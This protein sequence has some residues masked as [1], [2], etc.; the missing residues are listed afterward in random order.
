MS[1][2]KIPSLSSTPSAPNSYPRLKRARLSLGNSMLHDVT[3]NV[4]NRLVSRRSLAG[5][6]STATTTSSSSQS[7]RLMNKY[8][9]GDANVIEEVKKRERKILK[10]I[11]RFINAIA[12]IEKE[13]VQIKERQLPDIQYQISKKKTMCNELEKEILQLTSQLD[14]KEGECE[15]QRKNEELSISNLQF[16]YSVEVQE[17]ENELEEKLN[18]EK[19]NWERQVLELE[20]M[21]PSEKIAQEIKDLKDELVQVNAE[22]KKVQLDNETQRKKYESKLAE[23][24]VTFKKQKEEPMISLLKEQ[25]ELEAK[26][27]NL[28]KENENLEDEINN[29]VQMCIDIEKEIESL[30]QN[31]ASLENK[32]SPL[33]N[34]YEKVSKEFETAEKNLKSVQAKALEKEILYNEE[35]DKMEQEQIRRRKLENSIDELKGSIRC[36]AYLSESTLTESYKIDY[37]KKTIESVDLDSKNNAVAKSYSFT[38]LIPSTLLSEDDLLFQEYQCYHDMCLENKSNFNLISVGTFPWANLVTALTKF[39]FPKYLHD[40]NIS[41]QHVFLSED[42]PSQDLLLSSS[43]NSDNEIKLKIEEDSIELDSR[44]INITSGVEDLPS[45]FFEKRVQLPSG[46][47]I[48]KL[49]FTPKNTD[50]DENIVNYYFVEIYDGNTISTLNKAVT[51][52]ESEKTPITLI[53]KKLLSDTKSCFVFNLNDTTN[54][55]KLLDVSQKIMKL[56]NPKKKRKAQQ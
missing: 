56:K 22:W 23:E 13:T 52:G 40:Y 9:F 42:V 10:D 49:T 25:K 53:L 48:L 24:F 46:I 26:K 30:N 55:N 5:N 43:D 20:N 47:T 54:N 21:E 12:E 7:M 28:K 27:E 17:L 3:N 44:I 6:I 8:L 14:L 15:L 37:S 18:K 2:S 36:F 45:T 4:N 34:D 51:Y 38:R 32:L 31:F 50:L 19:L 39:L 29:K 16:K 35:F 11:N 1:N 41:L 33:N